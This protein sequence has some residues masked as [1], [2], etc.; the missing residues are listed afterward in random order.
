MKNSTIFK[1]EPTTPTI[2][3]MSQHAAIELPNACNTVAP[4][5]VEVG[6]CCV[7]LMLRSFAWG[8]EN[9]LVRGASFPFFSCVVFCATPG[10]G[11]SPNHNLNRYQVSFHKSTCFTASLHFQTNSNLRSTNVRSWDVLLQFSSSSPIEH[12]NLNMGRFRCGLREKRKEL[13]TLIKTR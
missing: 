3:T 10:R 12:T 13:R 11:Y 9:A 6:I 4:N 8:L 2:S 5:N 1:L 7:T